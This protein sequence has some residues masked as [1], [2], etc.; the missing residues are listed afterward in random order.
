M[1]KRIPDSTLLAIWRAAQGADRAIKH[2]VVI[3]DDGDAAVVSE[4]EFQ[5]I[6][7]HDVQG[8]SGTSAP[9]AAPAAVLPGPF[10]WP[11]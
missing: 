6:S 2:I 11:I 4:A 8:I 1:A 3:Q 9:G 7:G 10:R 5:R